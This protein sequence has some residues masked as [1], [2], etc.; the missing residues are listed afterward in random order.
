MTRNILQGKTTTAECC[1][2]LDTFEKINNN[3][4]SNTTIYGTNSGTNNSMASSSKDKCPT[5]PLS[6]NNNNVTQSS[7]LAS[8]YSPRATTTA[9]VTNQQGGV[10]STQGCEHY[11]CY[12]CLGDYFRSYLERPGVE[13]YSILDCPEPGCDQV[14]NPDDVLP[15]VMPNIEDVHC[16]WRSVIEKTMMDSIVRIAFFFFETHINNYVWEEKLLLN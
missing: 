15:Q 9:A 7:S 11:A 10:I 1:I 5:I 12:E 2:C 8:C 14:F 4:N 3:N 6:R 16:W 13:D